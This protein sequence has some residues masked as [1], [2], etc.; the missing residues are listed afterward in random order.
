MKACSNDDSLARVSA[1]PHQDAAHP[2]WRLLSGTSLAIT[3]TCLWLGNV[4]MNFRRIMNP[5]SG[6]ELV[7]G[8]PILANLWTEGINVSAW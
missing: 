1:Q 6:V 2:K 7:P 4:A 5:M 3:L 8:E